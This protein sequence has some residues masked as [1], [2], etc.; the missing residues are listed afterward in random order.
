MTFF[1]SLI[2]SIIVYGTLA[3]I[4]L[5]KAIDEKKEMERVSKIFS[6][7]G[8]FN[9]I[10]KKLEEERVTNKRVRVKNINILPNIVSFVIAFVMMFLIGYAVGSLLRILIL[11]G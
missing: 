8:I 6:E 11:G 10:K 2:I 4:L 1:V 5:M 9:K 7:R 3:F